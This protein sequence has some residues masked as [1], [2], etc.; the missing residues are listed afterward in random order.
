MKIEFP[1]ETNQLSLEYSG[2]DETTSAL[3]E[4]TVCFPK[5]TISILGGSSGSGKST[6]LNCLFGLKRPTKGTIKYEGHDVTN[7][8]NRQWAELRQNEVHLVT[9]QTVL[10]PYLT[11]WENLCF[12]ISPRD[13]EQLEQAA[14][15]LESMNLI[16][17]K[18][19]YPRELSIGGR[20][21]IAIVRALLGDPNVVL[22]DEPT[23]ALDEE[24]SRIVMDL[25]MHYAVKGTTFIV[26][27]HDPSVMTY[28]HH[29]LKL[30]DGEVVNEVS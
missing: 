19:R 6:L 8:S 9:Q 25:F 30:K 23:S 27:T 14:H 26:A 1:Y 11:I 10:F 18:H 4:V 22:A 20:Q 29:C 17:N 13:K 28:G 15:L 3:K 2:R 16:Q 7:W 5:G 21:R 24:N 12:V